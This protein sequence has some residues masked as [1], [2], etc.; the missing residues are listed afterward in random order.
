MEVDWEKDT[1]II[2]NGVINNLEICSLKVPAFQPVFDTSHFA[3]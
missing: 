2:Q 3:Q 1:Q